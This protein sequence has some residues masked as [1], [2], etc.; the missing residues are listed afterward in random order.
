MIRRVQ[1]VS[2][3]IL[4]GGKSTRMGR[5]KALLVFEGRSL[6]ERGVDLARSLTD[7]VWI[8][9]E[10]ARYSAFGPVIADVYREQ[11][12]LGGIHTGLTHSNSE[13]NLVLAVDLPFMRAEFLTWLMMEARKT[14]ELVT[15]PRIHGRLQPL[16]AVYRRK[17]AQRAERELQAGRNKI[18]EAFGSTR[19]VEEEEIV[20]HGY[21]LEMFRNVNTPEEWERLVRRW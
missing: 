19:I 17:F 7:D 9:G 3:F 4:V 2:A 10:P 16:C 6:V 20:A 12:P 8:V 13:W 11:G 18:A 14:A 21:S 1:D 5:D 15:V